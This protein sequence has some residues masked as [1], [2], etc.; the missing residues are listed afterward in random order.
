[1]YWTAIA[2]GKWAKLKGFSTLLKHKDTVKR[3]VATVQNLDEDYFYHAPDRYFGSYYAI[4]PSFAG[5]DM[6]K[7]KNLFEKSISGSP[8]Y[9]DTKVLYAQYYATKQQDR[10]LFERLLN[11]VISADPNA[12]PDIAPENKAAQ[13]KARHLLETKGDY[14]S[15]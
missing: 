1:L 3:Y 9:L 15:P 5:G 13:A 4:A 8:S 10:R 7:S 14:F 11:E 12:V 6:N 2:L